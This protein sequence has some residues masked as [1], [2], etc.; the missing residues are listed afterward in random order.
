MN[1]YFNMGNILKS[2]RVTAVQIPF[3]PVVIHPELNWL[4]EPDGGYNFWKLG[5]EI[6]KCPQLA[7]L[8]IN[9][10]YLKKVEEYLFSD[11]KNWFR[12]TLSEILELI[13]RSE[14]P[15]IILLP[16][17][18]IPLEVDNLLEDVL[19]KYSDGRC[20]I[21]GIGSVCKNESAERK[22]RFVIANNGKLTVG[23]KIIPNNLEVKL[24]IVGG[25]GPLLY[26]VDLNHAKKEHEKSYLLI[27]MCSDDIDIAEPG[28]QVQNLIYKELE[29]KNIESEDIN[30]LIIPAFSTKTK[31][32]ES[33]CEIGATRFNGIA[34]LANCSFFG[35]SSVWSP[36]LAKGDKVSTRKIKNNIS[37][38]IT[39]NIPV[40]YLG[41]PISTTIN[42]NTKKPKTEDVISNITF[43]DNYPNEDSGFI[44]DSESFI[45]HMT[46]R[47]SVGITLSGIAFTRCSRNNNNVL[48]YVNEFSIA[49]K[50]IQE[51]LTGES[52]YEAIMSSDVIAIYELIEN[53]NL[54]ILMLEKLQTYISDNAYKIKVQ[55]IIKYIETNA[56][57]EILPSPKMW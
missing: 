15:D 27:L 53:D 32:M 29:D 28:S 2:I 35:G 39:S 18:S 40:E 31:D 45:S 24:G 57:Y 21:G 54:Y 48:D 33:L 16:E 22:N 49:W 1:G 17:Y 46:K 5:K 25:E 56:E 42:R 10:K 6:D 19:K 55:E 8:P 47:L 3:I 37:A 50:E 7:S 38:C 34:A 9:E 20:I 14:N 52:P 41:E 44:L 4:S 26:E 12:N 30:A 13:I 43:R 36:P 11:Y 23:E 51:S